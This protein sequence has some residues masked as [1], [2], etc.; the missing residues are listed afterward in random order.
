MNKQ[1]LLLTGSPRKKG[2]SDLMAEAFIEGATRAGH[3]VNLFKT[4]TKHI[5]GCRACDACFSKG[6]ACVFNDDFNELAL[7]LKA[8]AIVFCTPIYWYSF[9]TQIKAAIDK[10]YSFIVGNRTMNIKEC[11]LLACGE[12]D[13]L[14]VFDGLIKSYEL[15]AKD[16]E[17][18]DCGHLVVQ[19]V[20][21]KGAILKTNALQDI[22]KLGENFGLL[23]SP[24]K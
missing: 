23:G 16:R 17:W 21:E 11:M 19:A 14:Q 15:I 2:N 22:R 5:N 24:L 12:I 4:A 3:T 10:F 18:K 20:N 1:I 6:N 8:D 9:P 13:D 7:L